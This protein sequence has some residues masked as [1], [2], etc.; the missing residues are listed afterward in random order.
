M[1][2]TTSVGGDLEKLELLLMKTLNGVVGKQF[3]DSR[4]LSRELLRDLAGAL[5]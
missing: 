4:T 2:K 5:V 1:W 3:G